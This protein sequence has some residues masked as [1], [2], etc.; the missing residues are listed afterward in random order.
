MAMRDVIKDNIS[1]C[2]AFEFCN[3]G[4]TCETDNG[5][6]KYCQKCLCR[7]CLRGECSPAK[8]TFLESGKRG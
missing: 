8:K 1:E 7:L 2:G 3:G 4:K 6:T 5:I